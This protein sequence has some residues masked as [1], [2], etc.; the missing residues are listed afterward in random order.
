M[1][2]TVFITANSLLKKGFFLL[3][4]HCGANKAKDLIYCLHM[5]LWR[6]KHSLSP[7]V[8]KSLI[9]VVLA[10]GVFAIYL[11]SIHPLV[12]LTTSLITTLHH[13]VSLD[14]DTWTREKNRVHRFL[15]GVPNGWLVDDSDPSR[16]TIARSADF[17]KYGG[18]YVPQIIMEVGPIG[19]RNQVENIAAREL[20]GKRPAL[21]DVGVHGRP[22][23]FAVTFNGRTIIDQNVYVQIGKKVIIFRGRSID[24]SVFSAFISTVKFLPELTNE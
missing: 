4:E 18:K 16:I 14:T 1:S 24:P 11:A 22:G 12:T 23:L 19:E 17:K 7:I 2:P 13:P 20:V 21:Y 9:T 3:A 10:Y 6:V 8:E 15:Y 5:S